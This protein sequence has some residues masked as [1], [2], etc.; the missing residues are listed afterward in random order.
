MP[1]P[2]D[3]LLWCPWRRG[4]LTSSRVLVKNFTDILHFLR[5]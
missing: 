4:R 5:L 2:R 1:G 3:A